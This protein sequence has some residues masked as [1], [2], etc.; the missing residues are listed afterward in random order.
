[1]AVDPR[2][3]AMKTLSNPTEQAGALQYAKIGFNTSDAIVRHQ[4]RLLSYLL[5]ESVSTTKA[6]YHTSGRRVNLFFEPQGNR[7][8]IAAENFGQVLLIPAGFEAFA[9]KAAFCRLLLLEQIESH[10]S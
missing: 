10:V 5:C 7:I 8:L 4:L 9:S 2:G 3:Q 6:V 1:M